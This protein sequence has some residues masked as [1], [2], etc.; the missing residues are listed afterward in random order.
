MAESLMYTK[1]YMAETYVLQ[2]QNNAI[3]QL[4]QMQRQL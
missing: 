1:R 4:E 2:N 3:T